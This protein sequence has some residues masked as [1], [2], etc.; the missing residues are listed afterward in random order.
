MTSKAAKQKIRKR[1]LHKKEKE[2]YK[3][4]SSLEE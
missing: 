2:R 1:I 3:H 4:K